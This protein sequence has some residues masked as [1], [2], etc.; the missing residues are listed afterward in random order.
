MPI[1]PN[2]PQCTHIKLNGLRC[3]SPALRGRALCYFHHRTR[4]RHDSYMPFPEDGNSIQFALMQVIRAV[5]DDRMDLKKAAL[6]LYALQ[7]ATVNL[8]HMRT[9]PYWGKLIRSFSFEQ[10]AKRAER[11]LD[12]GSEAAT[13]T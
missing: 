12:Q 11:A 8:K 5:M 7:I 3:G 6:L 2:I 1:N 9:E 10:L 4:E 13:A